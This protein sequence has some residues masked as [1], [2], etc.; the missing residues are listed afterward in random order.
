MIPI[1]Y[2]DLTEKDIER[3]WRKVRVTG[4]D[5]CWYWQAALSKSGY[6][7]IKIKD[8]TI[9]A[10]RLAFVISHKMDTEL[11]V[12]HICDNPRCCNPKHLFAGT[13]SQNMT[14]SAL[15]GRRN[16]SGE[17]GTK[18]KLTERQVREIR[19]KGAL[20]IPQRELAKLYGVSQTAIFYILSGRNW[21]QLV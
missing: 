17:N 8:D 16:Q 5:D 9:R 1:N 10:N 3:F 21:S 13:H 19:F 15:K 14:D 18:A 12:C 2:N 11:E 6:G 7:N 4:P 20:D